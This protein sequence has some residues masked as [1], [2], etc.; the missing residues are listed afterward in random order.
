MVTYDTLI[1]GGTV[2]DGTRVPRYR[3]DIAIK[4]GRIAEIGGRPSGTAARVG[5]WGAGRDTRR[6][7]RSARST[8]LT[9][10]STDTRSMACVGMLPQPA[11]AGS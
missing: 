7:R 10:W 1:K 6:T 3:A 5:T 9:Q 4:D 8:A 11:S 2:V